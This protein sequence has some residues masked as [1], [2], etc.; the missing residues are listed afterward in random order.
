MLHVVLLAHY[1]FHGLL[2]GVER[3]VER[4]VIFKGVG[5]VLD[6]GLEL[7]DGAFLLHGAQQ[8]VFVEE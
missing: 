2:V 5:G 6:A 8:G 3:A 1:P 7:V 4:A